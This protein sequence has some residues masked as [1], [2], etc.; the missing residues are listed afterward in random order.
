[1]TGLPPAYPDVGSAETFRDETVAYAGRLRAAG[2]DA[3][4]HVRPGAFHAFDF[5]APGRDHVHRSSSPVAEIDL[6]A[7]RGDTLIVAECN[8]AGRLQADL[9]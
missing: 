7:Y 6:I 1:M 3:E 5:L 2:G 4:L 9:R 8:S